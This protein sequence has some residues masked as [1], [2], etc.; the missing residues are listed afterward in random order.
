MPIKTNQVIIFTN[1]PLLG[2]FKYKDIFQIMPPHEQNESLQHDNPLVIEIKYDENIHPDRSS[3]WY[4]DW[5]EKERYETIERKSGKRM[6]SDDPWVISYQGQIKRLR[7]CMKF[8]IQAIVL[9][10][11]ETFGRLHL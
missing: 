10:V 3:I 9:P 11:E 5:W 6:D 2:F 7:Y 8:I 1:A 4:R